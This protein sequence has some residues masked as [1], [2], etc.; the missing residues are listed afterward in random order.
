MAAHEL[1]MNAVRR[2]ALGDRDGRPE[3]TW[4]VEAAPSGEVLHWTWNEHE[5]APFAPPTPRA[6]AGNC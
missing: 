1:T 2:D 6:S 4:S 5:G 3:V